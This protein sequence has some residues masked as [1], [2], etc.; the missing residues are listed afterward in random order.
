MRL[1]ASTHGNRRYV[2]LALLILALPALAFASPAKA[3]LLYQG[4]VNGAR[5]AAPQPGRPP[6]VGYV[7]GSS[8]HV[9]SR[10]PSGWTDAAVR[11][12]SAV[13]L[14]GL[15]G[16]F[17]LGRARDGTWLALWDGTK[18]RFFHRDS[19]QARFGPAGLALDRNGRAVVAYALWFPSQRTFLRLAQLRSDGALRVRP[20][21]REGFPSSRVPAAAAPV[22]LA[23]GE[24]RVVET[25]LPGAISWQLTGWGKLLF[26]SALGVPTGGVVAGASGSTVYAAWTE[27]FPTLGPPA[28]VL[29]SHA[30]RVQSGV[31]LEDAVLAGLALTPDGPEL[32]ANRCIPAAAFGL[33]GN[34]V[35]GGIVAGGGVDGVLA[36]YVAVGAER[37]LLLQTQDGLEWFSSP[38]PLPVRVTL[39]ADLSGRVDGVSGGTVTIYRE[40]PGEPRT[41]LATV[42]LGPDGAFST[43]APA[44]PQAVAYRA[45]YT[46][47]ATGIP[48]AALVR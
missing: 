38:G 42:P 15:A 29:A 39:N 25:F 37:R 17:V 26:S 14:D 33:E 43:P 16:R 5:L 3:E 47:P 19:R 35:C 23:S 12:P 45:V 1:H 10:G 46:E 11:F 40:R 34:G 18:L 20:V 24:I 30:E 28:V 8:V 27:A 13:E 48:Y 7:L 36:D 4:Q 31:A 41:E 21:T 22:V 32:A 2:K 9:A 44:S 6:V